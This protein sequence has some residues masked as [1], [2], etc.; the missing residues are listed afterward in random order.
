MNTRLE[1]T[2]WW[3]WSCLIVA[4]TGRSDLLAY[5]AKVLWVSFLNMFRSVKKEARPSSWAG[6]VGSLVA[7]ATLLIFEWNLFMVLLMAIGSFFVGMLVTAPAAV[8]LCDRYGRSLRHDGSWT[9][10]DY[11]Q[12]NWD[13]VHG[14]FISVIPVYIA[15]ELG[16]TFP[17]WFMVLWLSCSF[18]VFRLYDARKMGLVKRAENYFDGALGVMIDDSVAGLQ[19]AFVTSL[20]LAFFW[21]VEF[22]P[23]FFP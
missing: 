4:T 1:K 17:S 23:G 9:T 13:E 11:N 10:F 7:L 12:I 21:G 2:P 22:M 15:I 8:W 20:P 14:M 5:G 19:T 18:L 6:T 16:L 3:Q